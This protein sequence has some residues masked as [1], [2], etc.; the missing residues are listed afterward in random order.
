MILLAP[1][2][3]PWTL[4]N[5]DGAPWAQQRVVFSQVVKVRIH[6]LLV[7]RGKAGQKRMIAGRARRGAA[8][9]RGVIV[10][11]HRGHR[12]SHTPVWAP[13]GFRVHAV[14]VPHLISIAGHH[15]RRLDVSQSDSISRKSKSVLLWHVVD[16]ALVQENYCVHVLQSTSLLTD[17][18]A[19]KN[20]GMHDDVVRHAWVCRAT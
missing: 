7:Y 18:G 9:A 19:L 10:G 14:T 17:D 8:A 16:R 15:Q 2:R 12:P 20:R 13:H 6:C 11:C 3:S 1:R 5:A 4:P